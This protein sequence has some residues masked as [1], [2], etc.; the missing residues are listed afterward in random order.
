MGECLKALWRRGVY[1]VAILRSEVDA[2]G[3]DIVFECRGVVRH[4]QLKSSYSGAK[5]AQQKLSNKLREKRSG[6]A[7][8]MRFDPV[9]LILGPF[10]WY[11]NPP[12]RKMD[13]LSKAFRK[14]K[15]TKGNSLGIKLERANSYAVP[16]QFFR[17]LRTIDD[18]VTALFGKFSPTS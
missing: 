2:A 13:D 8:W 9:T 4:F 17:E 14:A 1:D 7:I 5:T 12:G 15:H 6:C 18:V 3:Y 10:Y 11:G 16:R